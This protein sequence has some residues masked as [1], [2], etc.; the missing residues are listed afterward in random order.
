MTLSKAAAPQPR[1]ALQAATL[2]H[3]KAAAAA[4]QLLRTSRWVDTSGSR[5]VRRVLNKGE[6]IVHECLVPKK[7]IWDGKQVRLMSCGIL[8]T[9]SPS[10]GAFPGFLGQF[11]SL[12]ASLVS[13][14][15]LLRIRGFC[16]LEFVNSAQQ[17]PVCHLMSFFLYFEFISGLD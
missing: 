11:V 12:L 13:F 8:P 4:E 14:W 9:S 7:E 6:D 16:V 1:S 10:V 2:K 3:M 5:T 15:L 17:Q